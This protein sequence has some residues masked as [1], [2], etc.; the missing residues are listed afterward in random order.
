MRSSGT[1]TIRIGM[2]MDP[3]E[4][5]NP[6]KDTTFAFMLEAQSRGWQVYYL[7]LADLHLR[8]GRAEGTMRQVRVMDDPEHYYQNINDHYG[9]LSELDIIIMRKDP[10]FD[11][12]YVMATYILERAEADGVIVLNRP[13]SLRD[14]NEKVFTAWFPQCC[15]PGLL[16]RSR[17][18]VIEFLNTHQK[19]VVKPTSRMGGQS[20]FVIQK[21]DPNTNVILEEMTQRDSR[22][23][24]AQAYIP[25]IKTTG[26]K[27]ILLIDGEAIEHG[28]A[29][30]PGGDDH[31]G[32]MAVGA[33]AEPA[34]LTDRDRWICGQIGPELQRRGLFFVGIDIIG[35]YLTEINVTSPTGI[36]EIKKFS[37]VDVASLLFDR[38]TALL[39]SKRPTNT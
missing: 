35:D 25:E 5:I 16:T 30:I 20:I 18:A 36:R 28:I 29:R 17:T 8:N 9:P 7:T 11:I 38:M 22:Y 33:R 19:I 6:K 2:V 1:D 14:A 26:D 21:G 13:S 23:I 32:N 4:T 31:R 10:P 37:G 39:Q 3:I 15:P 12:E 34:T 24:H 27:R